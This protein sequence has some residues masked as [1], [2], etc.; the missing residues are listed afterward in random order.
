MRI[1]HAY[2]FAWATP[3]DDNTPQSDVSYRFTGLSSVRDGGGVFGR[4]PILSTYTSL[5]AKYEGCRKSSNARRC[6]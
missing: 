4:M 3:Y 2:W 6:R 1:T 5:A